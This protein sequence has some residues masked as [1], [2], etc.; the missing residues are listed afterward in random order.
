[1]HHAKKEDASCI[2]VI[3]NWPAVI[4]LKTILIECVANPVIVINSISRE[5]SFPPLNMSTIPIIVAAK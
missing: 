2:L 5:D 4:Y 3:G 1:M